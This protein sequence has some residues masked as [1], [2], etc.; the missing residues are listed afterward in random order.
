M[1][2]APKHIFV[3]PSP[4]TENVVWVRH[5]VKSLREATCLRSIVLCCFSAQ[6]VYFLLRILRRGETRAIKCLFFFGCRSLLFLSMSHLFPVPPSEICVSFHVVHR[7]VSMY[8]PR[9]LILTF[10]KQMM[11]ANSLRDQYCIF[12]LYKLTILLF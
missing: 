11:R 10:D 1:F 6:W 7:I 4:S 9:E 2:S 8:E 3:T 5:K 12:I